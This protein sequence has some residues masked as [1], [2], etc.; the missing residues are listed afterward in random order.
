M[1]KRF[2]FLRLQDVVNVNVIAE[3]GLCVFVAAFNRRAGETDERRLGQRIAHVLG[4]AVNEIVLSAVRFVGNNNNIAP[5]RK[6]Q[7]LPAF[8]IREKFLNR[9]KHDAAA[10][11]V[12]QFA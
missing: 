11:D 3:H 4:K 8:F 10:G 7:M 9:G 2:S 1:R 12:Q 5:V 6:Q